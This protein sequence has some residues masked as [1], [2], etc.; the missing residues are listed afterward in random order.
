MP[1]LGT[2]RAARASR[3]PLGA[4][5]AS[6]GRADENHTDTDSFPHLTRRLAEHPDEWERVRGRVR[7]EFDSLAGRWETMIGSHHLVAIET[8]LH[9]VPTA[10]RVLDLGT[11]TGLAARLVARRYP[12]ARIVGLDLS[13]SMLRAAA[14]AGGPAKIAYVVGDGATLPYSD[15]SFDMIT[16]LN[17]FIFWD[18][19]TRVLAPGGSLVIAYS[20]GEN[21]PINLPVAD[22]ER[23]LATAGPYSFEDGWTDP[24]TW[25]VAHK[26]QPNK[27]S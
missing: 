7:S 8:A 22:V 13:E 24:G 6:M 4:T 18:E 1:T 26:A 17:V 3:Q 27:G 12:A 2:I 15:A 10:D 19:V 23:H 5:V 25:V 11:G 16:A 9:R 21:T 20:S 14:G